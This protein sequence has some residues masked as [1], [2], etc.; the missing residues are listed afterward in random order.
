MF[1]NEPTFCPLPEQRA[2]ATFLD[3]D[4]A[5]LDHLIG[6]IEES[7]ELLQRQRIALISTG[8]TD[9]SR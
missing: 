6:E 4:T 3:R 5:R 8:P 7:I 9:N 2:I 1:G